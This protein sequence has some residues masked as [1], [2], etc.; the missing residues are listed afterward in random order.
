PRPIAF[1]STIDRKGNVNL[2]PFSFFNVFS[3]NPPILV[4]SP[5]RRGRDNTT[6]HTYEN[7]KEVPEVTINIVNYPMV[8]QMSL[9]STEYAKGVNEFDK[10]GFTEV[11]SKVVKPPYVKEAPV[12]FECTV[13]QVIELGDQGGAGN[14]VIARVKM[15]HIRDEYTKEGIKLDPTKLDLVGRMGE[16]WYCH[17]G[18]DSMFEIPKPIQTKGIGV[19]HLSQSIRNSNILTSNHRGR[20]GN[21]E[22]LPSEADIKSM[23]ATDEIKQ[24]L[25][26]FEYQRDLIKDELHRR[27]VLLIEQGFTQE[28]LTTLLIVDH[29]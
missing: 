26:E 23:M 28:A 29:V 1:A 3:A 24:I 18:T 5:S 22:K 16:S 25:L 9:A 19:D 4:F 20:L 10:S 11:P 12:S 2:S 15:I 6:K 8:E 17:A 27:G 7:I 13:D 14:L 21:L